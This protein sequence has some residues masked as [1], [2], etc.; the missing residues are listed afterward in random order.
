MLIVATRTAK[1]STEE[2]I[3]ILI[4]AGSPEYEKMRLVFHQ[5]LFSEEGELISVE[6]GFP[7]KS[8]NW[9]THI[10][11]EAELH[12][13]FGACKK[14]GKLEEWTVTAY[15]ASLVQA[16]GTPHEKSA[17]QWAYANAYILM[18]LA[19]L[20]KHENYR[21]ELCARFRLAHPSSQ[22]HDW[23]WKIL[24]VF[25]NNLSTLTDQLILIE[26]SLRIEESLKK[27]EQLK[28]D[29]A[30]DKK[31]KVSTKSESSLNT[32]G[33]LFYIRRPFQFILHTKTKKVR[34]T[35]VTI[36]G[37]RSKRIS[38]EK[39][40]Y[41]SEELPSIT[42]F[43][44]PP[45]RAIVGISPLE[46]RYDQQGTILVDFD[47][48]P[49][50]TESSANMQASA[51]KMRI[52][53]IK[54]HLFEF[55]TDTK[56]L[57]LSDY[58]NIFYQLWLGMKDG[59]IIDMCLLLS[60][61][62]GSRAELWLSKEE[63]KNLIY[64]NKLIKKENQLYWNVTLDISDLKD[65]AL[66]SIKINTQKSFTLILPD[67]TGVI[68]QRA[69]TPRSKKQL[70]ERVS[71]ISTKLGI[72]LVSLERL[73]NTLHVIIKRHL[74]DHLFADLIS[75]I[76]SHLSPALYYASFTH[77]QIHSQY[78]E[79]IHLLGKNI[80]KS[81]FDYLSKPNETDGIGCNECPRSAPYL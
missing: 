23:L 70:T 25:T 7:F 46:Q 55:P 79:A 43:N 32:S 40:F 34:K 38:I 33:R 13:I 24:P 30:S 14:A 16:R 37:G 68:L 21:I 28:Q 42:Q 1:F 41:R 75:G 26:E 4:P 45:K 3:N 78:K 49:R 50:G 12:E 48:P 10:F 67:Q 6:N 65:S 69:K 47:S 29:E 80:D 63:R 44:F 71:E 56:V 64:I 20:E 8:E 17:Y 54:R 35:R 31:D 2:S 62:T 9:P 51:L 58:Q 81:Q 73:Q 74:A 53:H 66:Q 15:I 5:L 27:A 39:S 19:Q 59:S 52:T 22:L 60:M 18:G 76:S 57:T 72:P 36:K 61:L 11:T 77:D